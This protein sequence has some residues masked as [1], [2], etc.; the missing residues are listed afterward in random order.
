MGLAN[1]RIDP[2]RQAMASAVRTLATEREGL[3]ALIEAIGNGLGGPF[4]A[5]VARIAAADGRVI[6]SGMG[7]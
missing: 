4:V 1:P 6:V 2:A 3:G 5:A 7:K